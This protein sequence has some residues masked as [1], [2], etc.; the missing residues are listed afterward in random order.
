MNYVFFL[1]I[2]S[3]VKAV[4]TSLAKLT[5]KWLNWKLVFPCFLLRTN[6][7]WQNV[8]AVLSALLRLLWFIFLCFLLLKSSLETSL[9][10]PS[11]LS[12]PSAKDFSHFWKYFSTHQHVTHKESHRL[13]P[14]SC[15]SNDAPSVV[16]DCIPSPS[17]PA[18]IWYLIGWGS[19]QVW[20]M[21][22]CLLLPR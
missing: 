15:A 2:C 4:V 12:A 19:Y 7:T 14:S 17:L 16:E 1:L 13:C 11:F 8:L 18:L 6:G 10:G 5:R 21:I 9:C 3:A 20:C 22:G